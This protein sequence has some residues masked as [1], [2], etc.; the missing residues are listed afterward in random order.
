MKPAGTIKRAMDLVLAIGGLTL[1]APVMALIAVAIWLEDFGAPLY[2]GAR[3][4]RGGGTFGMFKFRTMVVGAS[5]SGVNSTAADDLRITRVGGWLRRLK[6][7]ELPQLINVVRGE[8]SLVGPRPQIPLEVERYSAR[9][10]AMLRVRPGMTDLASIVFADEGEILKGSADPDVRY[11]QII[12]PWKSRMALM[13]ADHAFAGA[14]VRL[15]LQILA[16]TVAGFARRGWALR[17]VQAIL[18]GLGADPTLRRV[19]SRREALTACPAPGAQ[20]T[21]EKPGPAALTNRIHEVGWERMSFEELLGR[22]AVRLDENEIRSRL[23]GRAVLVTGAGGSIGSELCRQIARFGPSALIGFDQAETPLFQIERELRERC[24]GVPFYAEI[25]SIRSRRRLEEVFSE[26]CPVSVYHAAAYKHVPL[27]EAH[28]FEAIEN[29]VFGT[30]QVAQTAWS[31]GSEEFVLISSD[32]AVRPANVLGATKRLAEL[33]C[34]SLSAPTAAG[35][36]SRTGKRGTRFMAVRFGNVLGSNGSVIP[37]FQRQIS[38]GVPVTVT[39]PEMQRFF[40]TVS[41]AAQLVLQAAATGCGGEIFVL[42]MGDPIRIV[43]LART[44]ILSN[45]LNP[46]DIPIRFSGVRPGEKLCEELTGAGESI[47]PT[48]HAH[49]RICASPR[50]EPETVGQVLEALEHYVEAR[51]AAGVLG[52]LQELIPDYAPSSFLVDAGRA[53][54][55]R[56]RSVVA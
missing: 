18:K 44:L 24:P 30:R 7:D 50:V 28:L 23:R 47:V 21:E 14:S 38:A 42:D 6:L 37:V 9:E 52:A 33:V 41:E 12:R 54:F 31:H 25:G 45:G 26:H 43:D 40:M 5:R 29:N 15:D 10:R 20:P 39:H 13:Y 8:M 51:D 46:E 16:L 35:A 19:A 49:V 32:K 3:I 22:P 56:A 2:A 11:E 27:M 17:G 53:G 55:E 48:G 4:A 34:L 36:I 1:L